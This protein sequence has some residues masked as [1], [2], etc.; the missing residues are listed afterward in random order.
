MTNLHENNTTSGDSSFDRALERGLSSRLTLIVG[1]DA[2]DR[3]QDLDGWLDSLGFQSLRIQCPSGE[4]RRACPERI[5]DAFV[6]AGIIDPCLEVG[7][8]NEPCKSK[9]VQLMNGLATIS[10][11]LVVVLQNYHP[12]ETT[13][14]VLSFMLEYLPQQIH[15]YL[16]S[17]DM[18][19]LS[20]IPRLRVRRQLEMIETAAR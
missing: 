2:P 3:C 13:D 5:F 12:C 1:P 11:D 15:L 6:S 16:V 10:D 17:K 18:P 14:R 7:Q 4:D 19:G 9:L 8:A 20:C